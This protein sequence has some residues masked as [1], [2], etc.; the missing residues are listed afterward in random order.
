MKCSWSYSCVYIYTHIWTWLHP[1]VL[2]P[3]SHARLAGSLSPPRT[4]QLLSA[5]WLLHL[6]LPLLRT[7]FLELF[8]YLAPHLSNLSSASSETL[9]PNTRFLT[10]TSNC[11]SPVYLFTCLLRFPQVEC[12]AL[13]RQGP[14]L[15]Y[16]RLHSQ[17]L[18]NSTDSI[19]V[20][21]SGWLGW[22]QEIILTPFYFIKKGSCLKIIC[23]TSRR[24]GFEQWIGN[25]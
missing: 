1:P 23:G 9:A 13:G 4:C 19:N 10:I 7:S 18:A 15:F 17:G 14:C 21:W 2:A 25:H 20:C 24:L 6:L 16:S 11:N 5:L 8:P 3:V 12:K 22:R